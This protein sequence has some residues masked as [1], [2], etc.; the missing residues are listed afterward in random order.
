MAM[1]FKNNAIAAIA[2]GLTVS[3]TSVNVTSG[4]GALFPVAGGADYF[5]ATLFL[6]DGTNEI[7]KCTTRSGDTL[8]IVRAQEGTTA[9]TWTAAITFIECRVTQGVLDYFHALSDALDARL[10]LIE[11]ANWVTT[12]RIA[13]ANVTTAKILDKNVTYAKLPDIAT[14]TLV[15]RATA[16]TGAHEL[17]T[18]TAAGRALIDDADAG[19]QRATM[20]AAASGAITASGLTIATAKL[21]GR[22]TAGTGA[23]EEIAVDGS[24]SFSA[25]AIGLFAG[26][27]VQSVQSSL[28]ANTAITSTTPYDT[29]IPQSGEGQQLIAISITP[30]S[31]TN[32]LRVR[33]AIPYT[34]TGNVSNIASGIFHIHTSASSDAI[35]SSYVY[36]KETNEI[37]NFSG[38]CIFDVDV[39][40]GT[41]S[42]LTISLRA[43]YVTQN[44]SVNSA[45]LGGSMAAT[46]VVEEIKV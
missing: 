19:A 26:G 46:L 28:N 38:T 6:I 41:T 29:T 33:A 10:D 27:V 39:V 42:A 7:V 5:M 24:L 36:V 14:N 23:P 8:T 25:T 16:G 11:A 9:R 12:T 43:G 31:A 3:G 15:G 34:L 37:P 2:S 32:K 18:L 40:S 1:K 35:A 44:F 17:I 4:K 22:T 13:D 20:G 30:K 21:A 45:N